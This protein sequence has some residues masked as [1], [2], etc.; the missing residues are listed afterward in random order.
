MQRYLMGMLVLLLATPGALAG[1]RPQPDD[2]A[3]AARLR[4]QIERRFG[5]R[6][7]QELG[8]SDAQATKLRATQQ[9]VGERRR[10]LMER[11][12]AVRMA[13]RQQMRPGQTADPDSVRQLLDAMQGG[14]AALLQLEQEEDREMAGYLTPVQRARFQMM[15]ERLHHRVQDL[16]RDSPGGRRGHPGRGDERRR[17][18][19]PS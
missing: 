13:L 14:R 10:P 8:L 16:R 2:T 12:R 4:A 5:E 3:R 7:R 9:R 1:Q 11:Q 18:P 17:S 19:P 6:V 15:R